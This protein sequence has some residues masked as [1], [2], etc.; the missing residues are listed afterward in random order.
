L[1]LRKGNT[2]TLHATVN[3]SDGTAEQHDGAVTWSS[4]DPNLFTIA[5]GVVTPVAP[6]SGYASAALGGIV[7]KRAIVI[8]SASM[9]S[10]SISPA[11]AQVAAGRS[12]AFT[13]TAAYDDGSTVDVTASAVWTVSGAASPVAA[14][15]ARGDAPGSAIV[16]ATFGGSTATASL[17]V[18]NAALDSVAV[19]AARVSLPLGD[20]TQVSALAQFS[21]GSSVDV[22]GTAGW[23]SADPSIASVSGGLITAV[24]VGATA[25]SVS[26][27]GVTASVDVVVSGP[28]VVTLQIA[29]AAPSIAWG[30]SQ[31]LSLEAIYSDGSKADVTQQGAWSTSDSAVA[32]VDGGNFFGVAPGSATLSASFGGMSASVSATVTNADIVGLDVQPDSVVIAMGTSMQLSAVGLFS[33]STKQDLTTQVTWTSSGAAATVSASGVVSG[34]SAGAATV[35]A[36]FRTASGSTDVTVTSAV[37]TSLEVTH[38]DA[39][40]QQGTSLQFQATGLFNDGSAQDLTSQV[41][42]SSSAPG[43]AWVNNASGFEGLGQAGAAGV[44]VITADAGT[45]QGS[46]TVTVTGA[47]LVSISVTPANSSIPLGITQQFTATGTYDDGS[48]A[49][50]TQG[51]IWS[52]SNPSV[53]DVA[54]G[55]GVSGLGTPLAPGSTTVS[56]VFANVTGQTS[57]TVA[58]VSLVSIAVTPNTASIARHYSIRFTATGTWSDGSVRDLT[59]QAVWSSSNSS[60]ADVSNSAPNQGL[61]TGS[62]T[63]TVTIQAAVRG[64]VSG[65]A[66]LTVT[67]ARLKSIVIQPSPVTIAVHATTRL[68]AWGTF[69]D[70]SQNDVSARMRWSSSNTSVAATSMAPVSR[71]QVTGRTAGTATITAGKMGVTGTGTVTVQ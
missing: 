68:V 39:I 12:Q 30:T 18:S 56:A 29:P 26:S 32:T 60:I 57:A 8:D 16:T 11:S 9:S 10:L 20:D 15:T 23:E 49:D 47:K 42:W 33:D 7:G 61:A 62:A 58:I 5:G 19:S 31:Q 70:G 48:T 45:M 59:A 21:D 63:G 4:S 41:S 37:L 43:V 13:A 3:Y 40:M 34:V 46:T 53:L 38:I 36:T 67:N 69:D 22:T 6:G 66:S 28:S 65:T 14:G 52:S 64:G 44:A 54:N 2:W 55:T 51:A 25:I 71:G 1:S 50:L 35:T 27:G 17:D 24:G